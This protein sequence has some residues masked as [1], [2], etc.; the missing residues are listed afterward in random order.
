M[1]GRKVVEQSSLIVLRPRDTPDAIRQRGAIFQSL[2]V[3]KTVNER[4]F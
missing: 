1:F 2:D 3:N 4:T